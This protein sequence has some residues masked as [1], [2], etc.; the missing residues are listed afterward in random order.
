ML[1]PS[2]YNPCFITKYL[3]ITA[4]AIH[5]YCSSSLMRA[6]ALIATERGGP[7]FFHAYELPFGL[8]VEQTLTIFR[9]MVYFG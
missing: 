5:M 2:L 1:V 4:K 8:K 3:E 7:S 9:T 6:P